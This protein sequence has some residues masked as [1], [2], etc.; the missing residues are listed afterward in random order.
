VGDSGQ[1]EPAV[2]RE[3]VGELPGDEGVLHDHPGR[4]LRA[5][6]DLSE[7][8]AVGLEEERH[9]LGDLPPDDESGAPKEEVLRVALVHGVLRPV[10]LALQQK[11]ELEVHVVVHLDDGLRGDGPRREEER[12][13]RCREHPGPE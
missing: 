1:N 7:V 8:R 11:P 4:H 9:V 5:P 2:E 13:R 12:K 10:G 3:R 6:D